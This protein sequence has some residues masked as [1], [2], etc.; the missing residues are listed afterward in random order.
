[1]VTHPSLCS[2]S[3]DG[4]GAISEVRIL[5]VHLGNFNY[6]SI[7]KY[8]C[9]VWYNVSRVLGI[10]INNLRSSPIKQLF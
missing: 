6:V 1:M 7:Q 10:T 9:A 2:T 3:S 5:S 8:A 4:A